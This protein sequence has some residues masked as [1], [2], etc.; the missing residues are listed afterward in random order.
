MELTPY[1][2][3]AKYIHFEH[4]SQGTICKMV[5]KVM[6]LQYL[7]QSTLSFPKF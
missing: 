6:Y 1:G 7:F 4:E 2:L 5:G 3:Q